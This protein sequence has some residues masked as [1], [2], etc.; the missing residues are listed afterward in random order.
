MVKLPQPEEEGPVAPPRERLPPPRNQN[1]TTYR[2]PWG[3][4]FGRK[5]EEMKNKIPNTLIELEELA[6]RCVA[7]MEKHGVRTANSFDTAMDL[8]RSQYNMHYMIL[9][10]KCFTPHRHLHDELT[11]PER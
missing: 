1:L 9:C 7:L 8:L 5:R 2:R 3:H 10:H 6:I 4:R 11:A